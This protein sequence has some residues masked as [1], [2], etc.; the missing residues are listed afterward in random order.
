MQETDERYQPVHDPISRAPPSKQDLKIDATLKLYMDENIV[1]ETMTEMN[2]RNEILA[3]V[4]TIFCEWVQF[5]AIQILHIPE[6]EASEA[7]GELFISGSHKLGVRE[8]NADI[9]TVCVAPHFCTKEHFFTSLKER[10]LTHPDVT[11]LNAIETAAI[12]LLS[13]EFRNVSID[14]LFAQLA[15]NTVPKNLDILD[16]AILRGVDDTTE[17][18]LNG[19]RVTNMLTKLI[20]SQA[21]GNFLIVLRCVR[22]WAKCRGIYG[23]KLGYLGGVNCNILVTFICQLYP[24][25][26]PSSLLYK[27]FV[28]YSTRDWES[29]PVQLNKIQLNPPREQKLIWSRENSFDVMSIITPGKYNIYVILQYLI[30]SLL[31]NVCVPYCSVSRYELILQCIPVFPT[32]HDN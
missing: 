25:A 31:L 3:Q 13:F 9:D 30:K 29:T 2:R 7:G 8:P 21:F 32:S 18:S 22:K 17:K 20:G 5:V 27:F 19:P 16:D 12:P 23:N 6:E 4:K 10:F 11:E 26:S 14:L 1:L 24:F 15:Q 28:I